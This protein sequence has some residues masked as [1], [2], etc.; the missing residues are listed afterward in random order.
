M[1]KLQ[2]LSNGVADFYEIWRDDV[3]LASR[4]LGQV[5]PTFNPP[6]GATSDLVQLLISTGCRIL[7]LKCIKLDFGWVSAPDPAEGA[8]TALSDSLAGVKGA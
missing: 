1:E 5:G 3:A 6:H 4:P 2:Y 8:Y 7:N